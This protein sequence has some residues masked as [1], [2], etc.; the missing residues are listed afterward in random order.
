MTEFV[1]VKDV[2]FSLIGLPWDEKSSFRKGA[3][4]A[5]QR[6]RGHL[7]KDILIH[8][9]GDLKVSGSDQEVIR[10]IEEKI[11]EILSSG[12]IPI[13]L[14][15]DHAVTYPTVR[16]L[17]KL[18]NRI[19]LIYIDAHPD[20]Y[21]DFKGDPLSH[22]C[23]MARILEL[24]FVNKIYQIG[25]RE[26]TEEQD[27]LA[28]E[29]G[30]VTF[31]KDQFQK[32]YGLKTEEPTYLSIDIDVLDPKFAPGVANGIPDGISPQQLIDLICSLEAHIIGFDIVEI[33]PKCDVS[34]MTSKIAAEIIMATISHIR[35]MG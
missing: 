4:L 1:R 2:S 22:A 10:A 25:I 3:A 12:S 21:P 35:R 16:A 20:L 15:G 17:G 7:K 27:R 32:A 18:Y 28:Q 31:S 24:D 9:C 34:D 29:K 8:D 26:S 5:P 14:G 19:D 13:V 11:N 23:V 33:N 6:I 30:I